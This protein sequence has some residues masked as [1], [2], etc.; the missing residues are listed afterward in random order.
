VGIGRKDCDILNRAQVSAIMERAQPREVYYLA[1][2]HHSSEDSLEGNDAVMFQRSFEVHVEGLLNFLETI[3]AGSPRTRLF[4]AASSHVFGQPP[5]PIQDE[6]TPLNPQ[7]VYG[8]TKTT[9]VH[10]CR[11]YRRT[12]GVHASVGIMYNHESPFRAEKFV[13][14]KIVRGALRI[15]QG[16]QEHLLLGDLSAAIDWGY[17]PDYV[18]A[19]ARILALPH[20]DDFVIATGESHS[21]R[22]FVEI[23]F[24]LVGLEWKKHVRE[25]PSL[26]T[27]R[28]TNLMGS[29][30]KLRAATGWQPSVTF[31]KMVEILLNSQRDAA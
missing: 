18:D 5:A 12:H 14:Q 6:T 8:I 2:F 19:M 31:P 11:F 24:A 4:Y 29:S 3:R 10:C 15:A 13:S 20:A 7:C 22:E 26:I 23:A 25:D 17:A 21:V 28:K 1:A 27:K 9:G 16:R 30:S